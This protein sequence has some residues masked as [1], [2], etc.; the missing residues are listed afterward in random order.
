M[1]LEELENI[2]EIKFPKL[3]RDIYS[4]GAMKWMTSYTWLNEHREELLSIESDCERLIV[5]KCA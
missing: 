5:K 2:E 4:S 3:F 1:N